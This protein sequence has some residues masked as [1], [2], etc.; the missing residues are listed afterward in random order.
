MARVPIGS[1]V[2]HYNRVTSVLEYFESDCKDVYFP[3]GVWS[4]WFQSIHSIRLEYLESAY[5]CEGVWSQ[6]QLA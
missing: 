6:I 1:S 3:K 5:Q 2:S 4:S